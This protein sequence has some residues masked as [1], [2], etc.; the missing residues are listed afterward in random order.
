MKLGTENVTPLVLETHL[1]CSQKVKGQ[2]HEVPQS[3]AG[4]GLVHSCECWLVVVVVVVDDD[5]DEL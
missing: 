3:S 5:D 1:F 2:G 4:V